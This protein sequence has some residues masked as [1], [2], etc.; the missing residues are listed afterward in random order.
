VTAKGTSNG[1][2]TDADGKFSIRVPAN[3]RT[4]VFSYVGFGSEEVSIRNNNT[5]DL[6]MTSDDRRLQE[7][8]VV[9][10][11]TQRKKAVT[12]AITKVDVTD[13]NNLVTP[14]FDKQLAGRAAGVQVTVPSGLTNQEPR[15]RIRGVNSISYGRDPLIVIACGIW[16]PAAIK[17][18]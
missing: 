11:G 3:A 16:K 2:Q 1:V 18:H 5:V 7:V 6:A 4:L 12:A 8:V 14:S 15:I 10:Y 17:S 9:G 13:I